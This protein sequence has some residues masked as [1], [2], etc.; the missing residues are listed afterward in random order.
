MEQQ[1]LYERIA[2][3]PE[4]AGRLQKVIRE[5]DFA[6]TAP[7]VEQLTDK[8]SAKAAYHALKELLQEDTDNMKMLYCQLQAACRVYEKYVEKGISDRIYTDT[9]KCFTRFLEE[10]RVKNGRMF[11]DRGWWTY[12][13]TS[14]G[15]FRIGT[16]EYEF[17][18][19]EGKPVLSI[20]IPSDAELTEVS[21]DDSLAQAERF[22]ETCYPECQ[23]DRY[24]CESWLLSPV[25]L[26]VLSEKSNIAAFQK[27]FTIL[28]AEDKDREFIEWL[29]QVPVDTA[30][31]L[32][33]VKTGLQRRVREL[34]LQGR[35]VGTALGIIKK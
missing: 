15:I 4:I 3:Q 29:Y 31:E 34:L 10:C 23:Y 1:E 32:L 27:R 25:L 11:F 28:E 14:M 16:L 24:I 18:E 2:L 13:Q 9:M 33:P 20:H 12:R 22:F 30:A 35:S 21:V 8:K 7:Y 19:H 5:M 17:E 26:T 6:Q